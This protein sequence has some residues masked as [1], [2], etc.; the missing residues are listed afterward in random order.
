MRAM[1]VEAQDRAAGLWRPSWRAGQGIPTIHSGRHA[2]CDAVVGRC[3]CC[4]PVPSSV[5]RRFFLL[6]AFVATAGC[7]MA[8]STGGLLPPG[9]PSAS[10][11]SA[12]WI[13]GELTPEAPVM[14]DDTFV[15]EYMLQSDGSPFEVR[16]VS[17][18]FDTYL[19]LVSPAGFAY[20]ND[21]YDGNW[22]E[23]RLTIPADSAEAGTWLIQAN[24]LLPTETGPYTLTHRPLEPPAPG[25]TSRL[26]GWLGAALTPEAPLLQD[27][28]YYH[29][30]TFTSDGSA[31]E[32]RLTSFDFDPYLIVVSPSGTRYENDDYL[33]ARES[34]VIVPP[35][36][37][38]AG[39]WRVL[40]NTYLAGSTGEYLLAQRPLAEAEIVEI[41]RAEAERER[42]IAA[43]ETLTEVAMM[44]GEAE[45]LY[46]ANRKD[47][48]REALAN[49][50]VLAETVV[51]PDDE[52]FVTL[53]N[54][55]A[56]LAYRNGDLEAAT[57]Y[58]ERAL[59]TV[60]LALQ[61]EEIAVGPD[62]GAETRPPAQMP[63]T[64]PTAAD[65]GTAL[66]LY[67]LGLVR[68]DAGDLDE[69]LRLFQRTL[70]LEEALYGPDHIDVAITLVS[71][72]DVRQ[73]LGDLDG[74]RE[75]YT[76]A[77]AIHEAAS[78]AYVGE[79]QTDLLIRLARLE[80]E[81]GEFSR[82][83]ALYQQ[84]L[85]AQEAALG[86]DHPET[87]DLVNA[88]GE[89]VQLQAFADARPF[90][91][92]ALEAQAAALGDDHEATVRTRNNLERL[93]E[94]QKDLIAGAP[95][96][97]SRGPRGRSAPSPLVRQ[98]LDR[99]IL[100]ATNDYTDTSGRW[101]DLTNPILDA[102]AIARE[103]ADR[104]GFDTLVVRNPTRTQILD[105]LRDERRA[106]VPDNGQLF[107]FFAG[108][109]TVD[110]D[111]PRDP[112]FI[113]P[114]DGGERPS[115]WVNYDNLAGELG[116]MPYQR[117]LAVFD[118]CRGGSFFKERRSQTETDTPFPP[119]QIVTEYSKYR[120][121]LAVTSGARQQDV[122]DGEPGDHS[123]FAFQLL[124]ALRS[125]GGPD[126]DGLLLF[127]EI[128]LYTTP[129]DGQSPLAG[130][131]GSGHEPGGTFFFLDTE[132]AQAF[133]AQNGD[134]P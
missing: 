35:D 118:A 55:I 67:N 96:T 2:Q 6:V 62:L 51:D 68:T 133:E 41:A 9:Q 23:S 36:S 53:L 95:P 65:A 66:T 126:A 129:I 111:G 73:R 80:A 130:D 83:R 102:E 7:A 26:D 116:R 94:A 64:A 39:D 8:Q 113:V 11:P 82:A 127:N 50:V 74:A 79:A 120:S 22:G 134:T 56:S 47:E 103:L 91:E 18:V 20:G 85:A 78:G 37:A 12:S 3:L 84:A 45:T 63:A 86:G 31:F 15:H 109:G 16:L 14:S 52:E 87:A 108:H 58:Y 110:G 57:A 42:E 117:V 13:A 60:P 76:R 123:P 38:E 33:T 89:I 71:L 119:S 132:R 69:A 81:A 92:R 49:A 75:D 101:G 1:A 54:L 28:T 114:S 100:F 90:Y 4:A 93:V 98:G 61:L 29:E 124:S 97:R 106:E 24:T 104:Y 43:E 107:V 59:E 40:V 34:R 5:M 77:L 112:G 10:L 17:P 128:L 46:E 25:A 30:V 121:R 131:F 27:S 70:G 19:Q 44:A 99:A 48:A 105:V 32:V 72:G 21:D 88:V 122:S 115:G 125:G